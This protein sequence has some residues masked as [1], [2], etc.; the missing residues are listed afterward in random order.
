[1]ENGIYIK[2]W[3]DVSIQNVMVF[4]ANNSGIQIEDSADVKL[5]NVY[6]EG[7][8]GTEYGGSQPL[9][10]AGIS[11]IGS[12]DCYLDNCYSDTN[13][14]G[15]LIEA[16]SKTDNLPNNIFLSEC[17]ATL[18]QQTGISIGSANGLV[19]SDSLVAG[20]SGDGID[21]VD[22]LSVTVANTIIQGNSGN[23]LVINSQAL[24]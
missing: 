21:I 23:G 4:Y 7:C 12:K 14:F 13:N 17:E 19:L 15:F 11:I 6:V 2:N 5:Q 20:S 9:L 10:G 16:N 8:G 22:S 18:C 3:F 1:M 24:I